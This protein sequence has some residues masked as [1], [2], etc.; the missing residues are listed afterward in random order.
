MS[1]FFVVLRTG[2]E[3]VTLRFSVCCSTKAYFAHRAG[4]EP[5]C[6]RLT[7]WCLNHSA[8]DAYVI[9]F[10]PMAISTQ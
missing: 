9:M 4:V 5:A 3:P 2:N 7:V 6:S 8:T 1:G 10:F